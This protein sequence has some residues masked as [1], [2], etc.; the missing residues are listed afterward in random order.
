[1][2]DSKLKSRGFFKLKPPA[3]QHLKRE[4]CNFQGHP[5]LMNKKL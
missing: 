4:K 1:M 2:T 5:E 3:Q